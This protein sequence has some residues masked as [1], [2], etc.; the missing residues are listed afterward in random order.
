MTLLNTVQL[1]KV[2]KE[3]HNLLSAYQSQLPS[4]QD[5]EDVVFT[6]RDTLAQLHSTLLKM[7]YTAAIGAQPSL[8]T[9]E[10]IRANIMK[11]NASLYK[12]IE[13]CWEKNWR[14]NFI[15][16]LVPN[17]GACPMP[18]AFDEGSVA[19]LSLL[20]STERAQAARQS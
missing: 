5:S 13:N 1:S 3:C 19:P 12:L 7:L 20:H 2:F 18:V 9:A 6:D 10:C 17:R 16:S 4:C 8:R 11:F 14:S 15:A